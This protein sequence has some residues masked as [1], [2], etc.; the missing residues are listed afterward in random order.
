MSTT[1]PRVLCPVLLEKRDL[2][3]GLAY[4]PHVPDKIKMVTKRIFAETFSRMERFENSSFSFSQRRR[5]KSE[6]LEYYMLLAS[7]IPC[8]G[9]HCFCHRFSVSVWTGKNH[10]KTQCVD[11][12]FFRKWTNKICMRSS[13]YVCAGPENTKPSLDSWW[14]YH[15]QYG[16]GLFNP[17]WP[18]AWLKPPKPLG[19]RKERDDDQLKQN[20]EKDKWPD[21]HNDTH[22]D[23]LGDL[24]IDRC[25]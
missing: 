7:R 13:G 15:W 11:A 3:S 18:S 20:T 4:L 19:T 8:E 25:S 5:T 16:S 1:G 12:F 17:S 14:R 9:C 24:V 2:S 6:V 10:S 23:S 21:W 22:L